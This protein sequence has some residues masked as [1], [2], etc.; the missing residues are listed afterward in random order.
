M[1]ERFNVHRDQ[2]N[3]KL[4]EIAAIMDGVDILTAIALSATLLLSS[5]HQMTDAMEAQEID[6]VPADLIDR[7][8]FAKIMQAIQSSGAALLG[9][10]DINALLKEMMAKMPAASNT[11]N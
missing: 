7:E 11:V 5:V 6:G 3:A 9:H 2:L 1:T 10:E 8:D 4:H